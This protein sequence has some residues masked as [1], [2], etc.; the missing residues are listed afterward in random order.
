MGGSK[1]Y[2][3]GWTK[4]PE[5]NSIQFIFSITLQQLETI[6]YLQQ[7]IEECVLSQLQGKVL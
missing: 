1:Q 5:F 2:I 3:L 6:K 7:L 4:L